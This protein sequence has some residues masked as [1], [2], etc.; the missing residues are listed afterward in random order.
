MRL[1]RLGVAVACGMVALF[2][3]GAKADLVAGDVAIIGIQSD[4][5]KSFAWV[6]LVNIDAGTQIQFTDNNWKD[7]ALGT[8]EGTLTFTAPD[9]GLQ[10]GVV[11][12]WSAPTTLNYTM[13]GT[14]SLLAEGDQLFAYVGSS[15]APTFLFGMQTNSSVF[16]TTAT[17]SVESEL[18]AGLVVGQTA[19]AVGRSSA[20]TDEYDNARYNGEVI[21]G[22][23]EELLAA[24]AD[25]NNWYKSDL[26]IGD[27]TNGVSQFTIE[28]VAA[29]PEASS[30]V[31]GGVVA[32]I[33]LIATGV[34]GLKR[35]RPAEASAE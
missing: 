8:S 28:D 29:V 33:S 19:L 9:G 26:P 1:S 31:V 15:A 25:S 16:Q 2:A 23:R 35:L 11:Q 30:L 3:P 13:S 34:V 12:T 4:T 27:L 17:Q 32:L 21:A 24:I 14:F 22:T 18:P 7:G 10:A 5:P 20:S 6:P